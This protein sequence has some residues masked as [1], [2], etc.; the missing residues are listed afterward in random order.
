MVSFS[1]HDEIIES[2]IKDVLKNKC[3]PRQ[4]TTQQSSSEGLDYV[5]VYVLSALFAQ[6]LAQFQR[7]NDH[8]FPI[9]TATY[10]ADGRYLRRFFR[11]SEF[12]EKLRK[13]IKFF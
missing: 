13:L 5:Y 11:I 8:L 12:R 2:Q 1:E 4:T 3:L 6:K 7:C 10:L 9:C